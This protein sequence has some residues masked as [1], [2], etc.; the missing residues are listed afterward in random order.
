[1]STHLGL[2]RFR[3][4]WTHWSGICAAVSAGPCSGFRHKALSGFRGW[5]CLHARTDKVCPTPTACIRPLLCFV[6]L[7]CWRLHCFPC[8]LH[9]FVVVNCWI[10]EPLWACCIVLIACPCIAVLPL[11]QCPAALPCHS[12]LHTFAFPLLPHSVA[13]PD[14]N[15]MGHGCGPPATS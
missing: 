11:P 2:V 8:L 13:H 7:P 4:W 6:A 5:S 14:H 9:A 15:A 3:K 12:W 10:L 1:M